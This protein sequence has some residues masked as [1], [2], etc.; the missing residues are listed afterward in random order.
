LAQLALEQQFVDAE[1][2][3]AAECVSGKA[4]AK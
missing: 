4:E 2:I 3:E 1:A